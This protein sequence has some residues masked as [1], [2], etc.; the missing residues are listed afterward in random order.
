ME[1]SITHAEHVDLLHD[2]SRLTI[3]SLLATSQG[4]FLPFTTLQ[5]RSS[6]TPGNLSS[7]LKMLENRKLI[8][9]RKEF[10][11]RRPRTTIQI[12]KEGR[13]ALEA[14]IASMEKLI[15]QHRSS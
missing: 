4:G 6:L 9:V 10:H 5:E 7:H 11:G 2:R 1:K 13:E 14:F 8:T 15:R 3:I 12:T